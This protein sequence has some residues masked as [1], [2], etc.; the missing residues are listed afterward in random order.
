MITVAICEEEALWRERAISVVSQ[1]AARFEPELRLFPSGE[2]LLR[3]I[4]NAGFQP[5]VA[6][7]DV[8]LRQSKG[9]DIAQEIS[10]LCPRCAIVF[11]TAFI[12]Y[13]NDIYETEHSYYILKSRFRERAAEALEKALEDKNSRAI[14]GFRGKGGQHSILAQDVLYLERNLKKTLLVCANGDTLSTTDKPGDILEEAGNSSF[15]KCHQS[16]YVNINKVAAMT[17]DSFLMEDGQKV[18]IS[19]SCRET[20]REAFAAARI[21]GSE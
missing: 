2:A 14:L 9:I 17:A 3:E 19:R 7:L 4:K 12:A 6:V 11:M 21:D 5:D 13:A 16:F 15:V 1:A 18:P 8:V 20:A 10:R